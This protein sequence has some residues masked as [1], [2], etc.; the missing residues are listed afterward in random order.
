MPICTDGG[1]EDTK[2]ISA[3][4]VLAT[5]TILQFK[6]IFST[7]FNTLHCY[8]KYALAGIPVCKSWPFF[9]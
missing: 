5:F 6:V 4:R 8:S 3:F 7:L 9:L 1:G 2:N